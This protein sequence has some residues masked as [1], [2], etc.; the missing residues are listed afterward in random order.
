M[1]AE[2]VK[3]N[4]SI[5]YFRMYALLLLLLKYVIYLYWLLLLL[6]L[7]S[8]VSFGLLQTFI[9][10]RNG[11]QTATHTKTQSNGHLFSLFFVFFHLLFS[12]LLFARK[13]DIYEIAATV[14]ELH[15]RYI[16]IAI[17]EKKRM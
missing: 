12:Q 7:F 8:P 1:H 4:E 3:L 6:P 2:S 13:H 9:V 16:F 5:Q 10:A 15:N 11:L 14:D 17:L